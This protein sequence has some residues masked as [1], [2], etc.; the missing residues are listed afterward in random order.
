MDKDPFEDHEMNGLDRPWDT[1][2]IRITESFD[3][4]INQHS[5]TV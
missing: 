5:Q 2:G 3:A 4:S 1:S